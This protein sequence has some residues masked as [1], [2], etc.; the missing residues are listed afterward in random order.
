[1][2]EKLHCRKRWIDGCACGN[3]LPSELPSNLWL[4]LDRMGLDDDS[5]IDCKAHYV[6]AAAGQHSSH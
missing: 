2:N 4:F 3:T 6:Q 5:G 1:M